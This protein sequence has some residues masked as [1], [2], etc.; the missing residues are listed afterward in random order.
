MEPGKSIVLGDR[1]FEAVNV[2][3]GL[4]L[5]GQVSQRSRPVPVPPILPTTATGLYPKLPEFRGQTAV[6]TLETAFTMDHRN[7]HNG[8]MSQQAAAPPRPETTPPSTMTNKC[9]DAVPEHLLDPR[10]FSPNGGESA[11]SE[12]IPPVDTQRLLRRLESYVAN[13]LSQ[14]DYDEDDEGDNGVSVASTT[15]A[16]AAAAVAD[17]PQNIDT[18]LG[19][20]TTDDDNDDDRDG[21]KS[22]YPIIKGLTSND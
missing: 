9:Q 15:T 4:N 10:L 6:S 21:E 5:Y 2:L 17:V 16:A 14:H 1:R 7:R 8:G 22:L 19:T 20:R 3:P 18:E 11:R 13:R 12:T